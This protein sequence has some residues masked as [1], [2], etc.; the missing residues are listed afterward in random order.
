MPVFNIVD[1]EMVGA[2]TFKENL[3]PILEIP[4]GVSNSFYTSDREYTSEGT[5]LLLKEKA[6]I[7]ISPSITVQFLEELA[8]QNEWVSFLS[9][10]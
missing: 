8:Q 6:Y 5:S 10:K 9:H 3:F 1:T 4:F 2:D 7:E